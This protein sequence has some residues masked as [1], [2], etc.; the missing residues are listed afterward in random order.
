MSV[1]LQPYLLLLIVSTAI[2]AVLTIMALRYRPTLGTRSF[3]AL[4]G[5]VALWSLIAA[6]EVGSRDPL[7]KSFS[8]SLK[9]LFIVVAPVAW[10]IFGLHYANR[11][12]H[13]KGRQ[14]VGLLVFPALTLLFV[15][16]NGMHHWMF[17]A[18]H[19]YE[20]PNH[21]LINREFGPWFW[22]HAAYSYILMIAGFI[23]LAKSLIDS[24]APY[25]HQVIALLIGGLTPW[26]CNL[27]FLLELGPLNHL[28]LTPFAFSVSGTVLMLGLIRFRL[29]DIVP[30]AR[31]VVFQSMQDGVI[32]VDNEV[33]IV[34]LNPVA[35]RIIGK[36]LHMLIGTRAE[37]SIPWWPQM[38]GPQGQHDSC[39]N[40][41]IDLKLE[42][43]QHLFRVCC[44][45]VQC[46]DR[47]VGRLILLQNITAAK[48]AEEALRVSEARFRSLTENAPVIIFA[49]DHKG[50][51][52]YTNPACTKILG[53]E[54]QQV[55]GQP[56]RRFV[57]ADPS[58]PAPVD[59]FTRLMEGRE[60]TAEINLHFIHQDGSKRLFNACVAANSD[61]EGRVSG[62]IGMAKDITEE[63]G[64]QH[65]FFQAQK[66]EAIG[67]LAGG[68]AHDFNNLLMG[69]QANIS[70]MRLEANLAAPLQE[71]LARI[72]E[73]IQSGASLTRQL[74]GYARK[75]KY[76]VTTINFRRLLQEAL[77][78]VQ[79]TNKGIITRCHFTAEPTFLEADRGQMEL[80]LLNLFVNAVDAMP[81]G[82]QLSVSTNI[83][84][85][86]GPSRVWPEAAAGRYVELKVSD[87]GVGMDQTTIDRVFEPF[88]TTKE[89]GQ[90]TGLGL[91][92]VFGTVQQHGGFITLDSTLEVGTTI[93]VYLPLR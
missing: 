20:T 1:L 37:K 7:T 41:V 40:A 75:G 29:L 69:M 54:R 57:V 19:W 11:L 25:R 67:T 80:V 51:V 12:P 50:T 82:G 76:V 16:T 87:T 65:Q 32:V 45:S 92:M 90:G 34:D 4:M 8:Y 43:R 22:V 77:D 33:R 47:L 9:Y 48:L 56:F 5:S 83:V 74:L 26:F 84:Q 27:A 3:A 42:D 89:I 13:L 79:R 55:V 68:I 61:A 53:Y 10:F 36:P 62:I 23:Y 85:L 18:T 71:K 15:A 38:T 63:I 93:S 58:K 21:F 44:S 64:L 91:S 72:E 6:F 73:Q 2:S 86:S 88:F 39:E 17:D 28:D 59:T 35:A 66:M 70:L 30:V 52:T 78:V 31:D 24:P 14:L 81:K 49:I 60:A 46:M